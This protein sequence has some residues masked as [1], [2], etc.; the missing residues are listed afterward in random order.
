LVQGS[1]SW[2]VPSLA[3]F[4]QGLSELGYVEGQ[5]VALE[6]RYADG[7]AELL[8][9]LAAE[10]LALGVDFVVTYGTPA[11]LAARQVSPTLP[12]VVVGAADPVGSG[13]VASLAHP[14]GTVTGLTNIALGLGPKRLELLK[15][16]LPGASRVAFIWNSANPAQVTRWKEL[17][18][19][20]PQLALTPQSLE[21]RNPDELEAAFGAMIQEQ[22]DAFLTT[23]EPFFVLHARR[24]VDFSEQHRLPAMY[25]L[26]EYVDAGGLMSYGPSLPDLYRR[27]AAYVDKILK[28]AKP[29]N[30]PVE[31]PTTFE[32]VLNLRT[33]RALRLTIPQSLL[34]QA[35][36]VIQ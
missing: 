22:P 23:G 14:G 25:S 36:E 26:R 31:Q 8:P 21:V 18:L 6:Y 7:R 29:A 10:L 4:R 11:T 19:A 12:I 27:A 28:G 16:A 1:A 20:A 15:E 32:L 13:L 33:A 2:S 3:A 24:I 17:Q 30:L 34:L 9:D 5:N 35:T